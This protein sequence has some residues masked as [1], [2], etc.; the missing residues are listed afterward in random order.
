MFALAMEA[1]QRG[2]GI[3]GS[4]QNILDFIA[5][6]LAD[7]T[8]RPFPDTLQVHPTAMSGLRTLWQD[9]SDIAISW[10]CLHSIGGVL[11]CFGSTILPLSYHHLAFFWS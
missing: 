5:A 9:S 2:M 4:T 1:R 8:Q 11:N 3:V 10:T 7:A 6:K